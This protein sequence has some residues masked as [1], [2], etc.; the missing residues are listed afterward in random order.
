MK[1]ESLGKVKSDAKWLDE[2]VVNQGTRSRAT[3]P[4]SCDKLPSQKTISISYNSSNA[5]FGIFDNSERSNIQEFYLNNVSD[6]LLDKFRFLK[7]IS[8]AKLV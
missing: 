8:A 3:V 4:L 2:Q 5:D 6:V 1:V 7:I